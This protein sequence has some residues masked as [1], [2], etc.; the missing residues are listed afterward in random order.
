M[1]PLTRDHFDAIVAG[2]STKNDIKELRTEMNTK[3]D[4][5]FE[6]FSLYS[7]FAH[8]GKTVN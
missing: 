4:A 3:F 1:E 6:L 8:S 2:L 5:L 7:Y